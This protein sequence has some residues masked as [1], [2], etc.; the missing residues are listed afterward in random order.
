MSKSPEQRLADYEDA[1][2]SAVAKFGLEATQRR[3]N[4]AQVADP[5]LSAVDAVINLAKE[6]D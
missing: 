5:D 2:K 6:P 3:V 4:A 1:M